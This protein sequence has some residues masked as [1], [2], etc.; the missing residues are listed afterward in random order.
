M[1]KQEAQNKINRFITSQ[2][3]RL[4]GD[5]VENCVLDTRKAI[6]LADEMELDLVEISSNNNISICK[7]V[8]YDKFLYDKKKKDKEQKKVQKQNQ[9]DIKEI[10]MTPNIDEHDFNFKLKNAKT[11]LL[12]GDKVLLSVF[13]KGREIIYQDQGKVKLLK[14][15]DAL[16]GV[17]V[18]ESMPKLEGKRMQMIIKPIKPNKTK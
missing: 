8:D 14:F 6:R 17:G 12:D 4:V 2:S 9:I 3:V 10:R 7:I 18:A 13:F 1:K 11:F 15:V 5:N 16:D